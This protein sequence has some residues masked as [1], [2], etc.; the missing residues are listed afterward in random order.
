[1]DAFVDRVENNSN[2]SCSG[3]DAR[4]KQKKRKYKE[5]LHG[6]KKQVGT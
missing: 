3:D 1:M 5:F 4:Q 6:I 2:S